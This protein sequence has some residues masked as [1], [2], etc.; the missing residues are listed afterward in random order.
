MKR[1]N[2]LYWLAFL[3]LGL[4]LLLTACKSI[5]P[6]GITTEQPSQSPAETSEPTVQP[7]PSEP[8]PMLKTD[9]LPTPLPDPV[10][11]GSADLLH[12]GTRQDI[13]LSLWNDPEY[14][15][16]PLFYKLSVIDSDNRVLWEYGRIESTH[17][18]WATYFLT[19]IDGQDYLLRYDPYGSTGIFDWQ[20]SLF[21]LNADGSEHILD[22]GHLFMFSSRETPVA[23][24]DEI[25]AF[26]E[27]VNGYF[28]DSRL[29]VTTD[30][31]FMQTEQ[32]GE[33]DW[34]RSHWVNPYCLDG[35]PSFLPLGDSLGYIGL[36]STEASPVTYH[37]YFYQDKLDESVSL[38]ERIDIFIRDVIHS[39]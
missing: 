39:S 20:Y 18:F 9:P 22:E 2:Q 13:V 37:E 21:S 29:L 38:S 35:S 5:S 30:A 12:D 14:S 25:T 27:K 36:Y 19:H 8:F 16:W 26:V 24:K 6:P 4:T 28:A 10:V 17:V 33:D 32:Y 15:Y 23:N 3:A 34:M 7:T 31:H 11:V 1:G